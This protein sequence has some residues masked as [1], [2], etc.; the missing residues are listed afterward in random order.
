M[1]IYIKAVRTERETEEQL[2]PPPAQREEGNGERR[3]V[4]MYKN[5]NFLSQAFAGRK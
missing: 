3:K 2:V 4:K 5:G 1:G